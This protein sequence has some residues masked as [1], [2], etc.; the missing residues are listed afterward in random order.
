MESTISE[1]RVCVDQSQTPLASII[2]KEIVVK[3]TVIV[4]M[5]AG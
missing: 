3:G 1:I 5:K 2:N 4:L